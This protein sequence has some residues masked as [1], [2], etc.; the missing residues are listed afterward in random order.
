MALVAAGFM[1]GGFVGGFAGA[2]VAF[3]GAFVAALGAA[4]VGDWMGVVGVT[5]IACD[6][7]GVWLH[8]FM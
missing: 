8:F 4:L 3:V 2:F 7:S 5:L 1:S 6:L